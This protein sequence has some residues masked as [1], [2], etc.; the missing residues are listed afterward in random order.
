MTVSSEIEN[1][2]DDS[3]STDARKLREPQLTFIPWVE[4]VMLGVLEWKLGPA[5]ESRQSGREKE[6]RRAFIRKTRLGVIGFGGL[7]SILQGFCAYFR[8]KNLPPGRPL[9]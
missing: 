8:Q 5:Q 9:A 2:M 4:T 3:S 7:G 1:R 6:K